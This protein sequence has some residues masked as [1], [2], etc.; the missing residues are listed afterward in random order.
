MSSTPMHRKAKIVATI[1]PSSQEEP[2][3]RRLIEAG[4]DVARLNFS[5][6][7][8]AEHQE[9]IERIRRLAAELNKPISIL[10][11]LQ[12]PKLRV[13]K[14]PAGGIEL[15]AGQKVALTNV[16][17]V[18]TPSTTG[19]EPITLIPM[20]VPNLARGVK[21][22]SRIL[23]DDGNL[24]MEVTGVEGDAVQARVVLGGVLSSNKGV[25]LPGAELGITSFTEKD[26]TD[27]EFGLKQ[28][29]DLVAISFVR[30]ASDIESV[31]QAM[32]ELD[33]GHQPLP[34][35]AKLE[36]PEALDNLHEIIHAADG[37]MVARGDLGVETSPAQVP[38]YQKKI[39]DM[40]NRHAKV[41]I[42]ATQ[43]LDSMINNPRPTRAEAS[44]VANAIFD[45]TDA[46]ML[47][48]ETASGA[49]PVE[50]VEMMASIVC[51][52]EANAGEYGHTLSQPDEPYQD[53]AYSITQAARELAHDRNVAGIT[54]FTESG[55]TAL[56]MSKSRP[57]VPIYAF[58]PNPTTFRRL[59]ILW[60]VTPFL[61]P[62]ASTVESM[63][64]SVE[65]ALLSSTAV[66]TG[67]QVIVIS[68]FPVGTARLPN[69]AL[70][71]TVGEWT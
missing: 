56:L 10:Q 62:F 64:S 27:L 25:N 44:D 29:V 67:K 37:V 33:P 2:V 12:G 47:S 6:G 34:I 65:A 61:V 22:G 3:L 13:G 69:F 54:V 28:G 58:T 57:E 53:D 38:I 59:N 26:R 15:V 19:S 48:G 35:I 49:Y 36:R 20:D 31:R 24:E 9:K 5:H 42:T 50:A 1:G 21:A 68:G 4:I 60:G 70:L 17:I 71:Y 14:L 63:I 39:I 16:E 46:V 7:T 32:R 66:E 43:M 8:H 51:Q 30:T 18:E 41:V 40:A 55:R 52:A 45:G 11:D 23:L